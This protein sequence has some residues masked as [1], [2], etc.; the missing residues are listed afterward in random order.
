MTSETFV[1]V[2]EQDQYGQYL[3]QLDRLCDQFEACWQSGDRPSLRSF[4]DQAPVDMR[5]YAFSELIALDVRYR[6]RHGEHPCA[7]DYVNEFSEFSAEI[8]KQFGHDSPDDSAEGMDTIITGTKIPGLR[9]VRLLGR[10]GMGVVYLAE[11]KALKRQ[12]AVKMLRGGYSASHEERIRFRHEAE[13]AASLQH[14][15]I[16][17]IFEVGEHEGQPYC[18]LEYVAGETLRDLLRRGPQPP[19]VAAELIALLAS[20]LHHAHER[21]VIHRDLK[22]ANI[23]LEAIE[24][25]PTL[26]AETAA[27]TE[28][29]TLVDSQPTPRWASPA[30]IVA[31][32]GRQTPRTSSSQRGKRAPVALR[33]KVSDFGLARRLESDDTA[34]TQTGAILGTPTYMAP[35]Q[36]LGQ[37]HAVSAAIDVHALGVVL[38]ELLTGRP[39][40]QA[41]SVLETLEL[42]RH[43]DPVAPRDLQPRV[44]R[45]LNTICLKCLQKEPA[46]RYATAWDLAE[47]L[48]RFLSGQP[49]EARPV[50]R[51]ERAWKWAKRRPAVA[52]LCAA[53]AALTVVAMTTVT[54]LW[55]EADK[56]RK[57]ADDTSRDA[58]EAIR[59]Y[60]E[61]AGTDPVFRKDGMQQARER[62]VDKALEYFQR[63]AMVRAKDPALASDVADA[64]SRVAE[65]LKERGLKREALAEY[66]AARELYARLLHDQPDNEKWQSRVLLEHTLT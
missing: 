28:L 17:Q 3:H 29:A 52:G 62:L 13:S 4:V 35:E 5:T 55:W 44:P 33:P 57:V 14:P 58:R 25:K 15:N 41:A 1:T 42:I 19:E 48:H 10:G 56:Q 37:N 16:V 32:S 7:A 8:Y 9:L 66:D 54:V 6:E 30:T 63:F 22:P 36:A 45:D 34:Q 26:S 12:V 20:A 51:L 47:D 23:L 43:L 27:T 64:H 38:Y 21:G 2:V 61:L 59:E 11:Q 50:G 31:E 18:V 24:S 40:H 49:I 53:L 60:L 39:P 65:I 46:R